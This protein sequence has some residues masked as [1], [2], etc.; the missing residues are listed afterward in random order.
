MELVKDYDYEI[1]YHLR[2]ANVVVDALS[3]RAPDILK[4]LRSM[5]PEL[6]TELTRAEIDFVIGGLANISLEST[7]LERIC[8]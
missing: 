7:L 1:L 5:A 3:R 6:A 2:K 8:A 4:S